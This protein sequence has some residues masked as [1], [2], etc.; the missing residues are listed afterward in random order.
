[1]R[2][3]KSAAAS[4]WKNYKNKNAHT[5]EEEKKSGKF[6]GNNWLHIPSMS[7]HS[8]EPFSARSNNPDYIVEEVASV[9][10][11]DESSNSVDL[12]NEK[13]W[14]TS[15]FDTQEKSNLHIL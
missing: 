8:V 15:S 1:M 7:G 9:S 3:T 13:R 5:I 12:N 4:K 14:K 2:I 6:S 11:E 10:D